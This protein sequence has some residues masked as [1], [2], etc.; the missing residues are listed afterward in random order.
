MPKGKGPKQD[1]AG[2]RY[3]RLVAISFTHFNEKF[4]DCW[5]FR[6]DCGTEKVMPPALWAA[7]ASFGRNVENF[8]PPGG[9]R[10][11]KESAILFSDQM[12]E[13]SPQT[14]LG[15]PCSSPLSTK[16]RSQ[17]SLAKTLRAGHAEGRLF[18]DSL[19]PHTRPVF[20]RDAFFRED[21]HSISAISAPASAARMARYTSHCHFSVST[22]PRGLT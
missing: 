15:L 19:F 21:S 18:F 13:R 10:P 17:I 1:I 3:G 7:A 11:R 2:K 8:I 6:C 4:D 20:F 5:L 16:R 12:L 22:S 14:S 9:F